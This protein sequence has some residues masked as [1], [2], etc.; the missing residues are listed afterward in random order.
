VRI[1][2]GKIKITTEIVSKVKTVKETKINSQRISKIKI[3]RKA[4]K[5]YEAKAAKALETIDL[6]LEIDSM[7]KKVK[8]TVFEDGTNEQFL[9]LIKEFKIC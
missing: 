6:K 8:L 9:K 1:I 3:K 2:K 7:N 5:R 4:P